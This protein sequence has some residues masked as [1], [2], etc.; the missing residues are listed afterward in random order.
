MQHES[1]CDW[2]KFRGYTW[3]HFFWLLLRSS[4]AKDK[5]YRPSTRNLG[6]SEVEKE[7]RLQVNANQV[8]N[9]ISGIEQ[10]L[11]D[12]RPGGS[13][14]ADSAGFSLHSSSRLGPFLSGLTS[15]ISSSP[16]GE[17]S[18]AS[19]L[20][21]GEGLYSASL[22]NF[23]TFS[24]LEFRLLTRHSKPLPLNSSI[25]FLCWDT[26]AIPS[27]GVGWVTRQQRA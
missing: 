17:G 23:Y 24:L 4:N 9:P 2:A 10:W 13:M 16:S 27:V 15:P 18:L 6:I 7:N 20:G 25:L 5:Q 1:E 12:W 8:A 19:H 22:C 11:L 21:G 26:D 14:N 3:N